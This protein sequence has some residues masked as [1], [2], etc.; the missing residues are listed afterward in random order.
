MSKCKQH[1]KYQAKFAPRP[2]TKNPG[3]CKDCWSIYTNKVPTIFELRK[4]AKQVLGKDTTM[5]YH[6]GNSPTAYI[7]WSRD[8][9]GFA[10]KVISFECF[11][12]INSTKK[13]IKAT[14][15]GLK[16]N[17]DRLL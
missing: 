1:P 4:L 6:P 13:L 14:L 17:K 8:V 16:S 10:N 5:E 12:D 15:L 9:A 11:L 7:A 2:T 3:G